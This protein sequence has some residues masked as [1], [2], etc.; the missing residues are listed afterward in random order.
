MDR[1]FP[2]SALADRLALVIS[3]QS[4]LPDNFLTTLDAMAVRVRHDD[5]QQGIS[6]DHIGVPDVLILS[7]DSIEEIDAFVLLAARAREIHCPIIF[8]TPLE[9]VDTLPDPLWQ[10]C[11]SILVDPDIADVAAALALALSAQPGLLADVS[12]DLDAARLQRLADEVGRIARTLS[13]L[14][15]AAPEADP[16][17]ADMRPDF[18]ADPVGGDDGGLSARHIRNMIRA[19]RL[20]DRYFDSHLFADPAW[21]MLLDLMAARLERAQVAVSSLCIAACVPPT[22]ALRWIKMMTQNGVFERLSDPNDRRR[23]FIRLS[24][25]AAQ[26]M[27]RLLS[28]MAASSDLLI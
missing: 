18:T 26:S 7:L 23:V 5:P 11:Q 13:S 9:L 14:S 24:D 10:G 20:R 27:T 19:R 25:D 3:S 2:Q 17:L 28:E 16:G 21:D 12:R 4:A 1:Y 15:A 8:I 6:A 22:T